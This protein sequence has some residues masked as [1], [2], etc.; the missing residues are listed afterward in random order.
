ML[1]IPF[2]AL[3]GQQEEHVTCKIVFQLHVSPKPSSRTRPTCSRSRKEGRWTRIES[4][5]SE[6]Q[7]TA[8]CAGRCACQHDWQRLD[9]ITWR[10]V[11]VHTERCRTS[12]PGRM[13]EEHAVSELQLR[14]HC[15]NTGISAS[16]E[17][18]LSRSMCQLGRWRW[19][20]C[21]GLVDHYVHWICL[22]PFCF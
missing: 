2:S 19:T 11:T 10:G 20:M 13:Q 15:G 1:Y 16:S 17:T 6:W 3:T 4:V 9:T 21:T 12:D 8:M 14:R 5:S 18:C 7:L 22:R